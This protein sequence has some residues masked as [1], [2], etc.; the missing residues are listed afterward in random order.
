MSS[1][2]LSMFR[3]FSYVFWCLLMSF[4]FFSCFLSDRVAVRVLKISKGMADSPRDILPDHNLSS[5]WDLCCTPGTK[6]PHRLQHKLRRLD[7]STPLLRS[8]KDL[9][10]Y[11][12]TTVKI[13]LRIQNDWRVVRSCDPLRP[14][15][16]WL[17]RLECHASAVGSLQKLRRRKDHHVRF[18]K[19]TVHKN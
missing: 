15:H 17:V 5:R 16:H 14:G 11:C 3:Q 18:E 19:K 1:Y 13:V 7:A 2:D 10:R 8:V 6:M 12:D 9:W 4:V